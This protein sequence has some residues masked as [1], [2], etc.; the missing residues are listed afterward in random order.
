[1]GGR[2]MTPWRTFH[3]T[4]NCLG[5]SAPKN[6]DTLERALLGFLRKRGLPEE[7]HRSRY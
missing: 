4:D 1:M 3:I 5:F 6:P 2:Q 7:L